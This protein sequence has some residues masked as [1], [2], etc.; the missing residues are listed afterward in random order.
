MTIEDI[1]LKSAERDYWI[2]KGKVYLVE[3]CAML[4]ISDEPV[5][6]LTSVPSK[7]LQLMEKLTD[8]LDTVKMLNSVTP[9]A[10]AETKRDDLIRMEAYGVCASLLEKV[11]KET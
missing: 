7:Y 11:V 5:A 2:R 9:G 1:C 4:M 3:G 8:V 6:N 10:D